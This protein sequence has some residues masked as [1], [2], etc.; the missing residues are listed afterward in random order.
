MVFWMPI[1]AGI[2]D[3]SKHEDVGPHLDHAFQFAQKIFADLGSSKYF[4]SLA[5]VTIRRLQLL[6]PGGA[7]YGRDQGGDDGGRSQLSYPEQ[8]SNEGPRQ[9]PIDSRAKEELHIHGTTSAEPVLVKTTVKTGRKEEPGGATRHIQ[10]PRSLWRNQ[11]DDCPRRSR[12][13]E[14]SR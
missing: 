6:G 1:M 13:D 4:V 7:G 11:G 3:S 12:R 2:S 9:K 5:S 8:C 10:R 14:G